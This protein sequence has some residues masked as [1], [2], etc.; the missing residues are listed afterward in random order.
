ALA[1]GSSV[2]HKQH[3]FPRPRT[4]P[5]TRPCQRSPMAPTA[6]TA[7]LRLLLPA[8]A[9]W[10]ATLVASA[11]FAQVVNDPPVAPL[12]IIAFPQRDFVSASGYSADDR[13]VVKVIHPGGVTRTTDPANPLTPLADPGAPPGDPFAG[14]IEVNH[15]GG[16]CWFGTTPDIRPGDVVRIDIVGGPR[17]GRSDA[18][19]VSN[20]TDVAPV[21]D[22]PDVVIHGTA[23]DAAGN[24]IPLAQ[25]EQRLVT[26]GGLFDV[27][28]RRTLRAG[29]AG[30]GEGTLTYDA[31]GSTHWTARYAGLDA[32]DI[33]TALAAE[34]RILW[35]GA[36]PGAGAELTIYE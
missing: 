27:N 4:P 1:R 24:P 21:Q 20:V 8:A 5:R 22:G 25:I 35:L 33:S 32:T 15:P 19:V 18:T 3:P 31:P 11:A 23:Q 28:G 13:V 9:C 10:I 12:S 2:R 6:P 36:N 29:G 26:S 7:R 34:S 30:G 14:L 16:Y 17:A